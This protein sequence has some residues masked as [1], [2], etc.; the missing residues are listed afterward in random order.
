MTN[1][2]IRAAGALFTAWLTIASAAGTAGAT[3]QVRL[4]VPYGIATAVT[5]AATDWNGRVPGANQPGCKPSQQHPNPVLLVGSTFLSD[6]VNWTALAPYLHN[7]GYCVYTFELR[8][9][10]LSCPSWH[11]RPRPDAQVR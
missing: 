3:P 8:Q 7:S 2:I 6:A 5:K 1:R 4:P 9:I 10:H 11:Q